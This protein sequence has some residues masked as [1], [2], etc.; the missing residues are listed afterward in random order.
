MV[1]SW[2]PRWGGALYLSPRQ[3]KYFTAAP[4]NL[5]QAA[6]I[7]LLVIRETAMRQNFPANL[8][9]AVLWAGLSYASWSMSGDFGPAIIAGA[10][11]A[12]ILLIPATLLVAAFVGPALWLRDLI[13]GD[14]RR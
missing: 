11:L 12:A 5:P 10:I 13:T 3:L 2:R 9:F 14:R 4:L 8:I 7:H 1:I 6:Q